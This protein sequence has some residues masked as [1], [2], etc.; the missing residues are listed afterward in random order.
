MKLAFLYLSLN[1][2][3]ICK[4]I[5]DLVACLFQKFDNDG[6]FP[7]KRV[8]RVILMETNIANKRRLIGNCSKKREARYLATK[9]AHSRR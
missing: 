3:S 8:P 9:R 6:S 2:S 7:Q 5:A 4:I 1:H